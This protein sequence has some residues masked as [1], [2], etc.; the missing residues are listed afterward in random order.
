MSDFFFCFVGSPILILLK[1]IFFLNF[2]DIIGVVKSVGDIF[3]F[4]AK[5]TNK[6]LKKREVTLVDRSNTAVI[7]FLSCNTLQFLFPHVK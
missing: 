2:S 6:E 1:Y 7:H 4:T 3:Q 5:T